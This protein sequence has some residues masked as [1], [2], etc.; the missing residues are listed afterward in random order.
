[1]T[2]LDLEEGRKKAFL[3]WRLGVRECQVDARALRSVGYRY[4]E[5]RDRRPKGTQEKD[6]C[7]PSDMRKWEDCTGLAG[8]FYSD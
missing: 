5:Y 1:M 6:T 7:G 4:P 2:I 8:G 3:S